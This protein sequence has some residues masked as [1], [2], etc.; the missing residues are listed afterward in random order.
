[1]A[2]NQIG[3]V[4]ARQIA[5]DHR[6]GSIRLLAIAGLR[7]LPAHKIRSGIRAT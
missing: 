4:V 1:M 3:L 5:L 7:D 2:D 6:A